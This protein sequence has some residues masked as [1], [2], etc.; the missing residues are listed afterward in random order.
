MGSI[1]ENV[2]ITTDF[3][4]RLCALLRRRGVE[5]GTRQVIACME[6]IRLLEIVNEDELKRVYRITLINRKQDLWHL[7]RAYELLL[8]DYLSPRASAEEEAKQEARNSG[9]V[10]KQYR[11]EESSSNDPGE[12]SVISPGYSTREVDHCRD[13]RLIPQEDV[14]A[15]MAALKRL[16]RKHASLARRKSKRAKRH[17]HIDLRGSCRDSVKF[18]GEIIRWRYKRKMAT[19]SRLVIVSDVSGSMEVYSSFLLNFLYLLNSAR[20]FRMATFVFSTRLENLSRQFRSRSFPEML[21]N[22]ALHFS[23]WSG[24]TKIGRAIQTLNETYGPVVTPKTT[25]VIMSDGWDTGDLELLDREMSKLRSR[26]RSIVWINPLKG[27]P[28]YEPLAAGMAT[29]LPYC[30]EF[31]AGHSI[32]SLA[33]LAKM[34]GG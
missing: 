27:A 32:N 34:L 12:E 13:F 17:G 1:L 6:A 33:E 22:V 7:Y 18:D 10:R 5:V 30:D 8:K 14:P 31:I 11:S 29:T 26:A 23:G 2:W 24:G 25:V 21:K 3:S 4:L 19:R 16:A 20:F 15:A 28:A 9:A